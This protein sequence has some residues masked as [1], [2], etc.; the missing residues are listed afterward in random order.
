MWEVAW[1]YLD[2]FLQVRAGGRIPLI[3]GRG[4]TNRA[5]DSM[6]LGPTTTFKQ[7]A[8]P[9]VNVKG[10]SLAQKMVGKAC[11]VDGV[12]PGAYCEPKM[13][14]VG[15]QDTTGPMTRD[16]L[17]DLACLGF[18]ADLVMQS[19]CHTAAYPKPVDVAA[20]EK[21]GDNFG[22]HGMWS[23]RNLKGCLDIPGYFCQMILFQVIT[24][25]TLPKF[26]ADRGGVALRPGDGII[27]SWLNRM[28]LPDEVGTGTELL[29][30]S[31]SE[32]FDVF[33]VFLRFQYV[34]YVSVKP[35]LEKSWIPVAWNGVPRWGFAHAFPTWNFIPG[36]FWI[37]GL[38]SCHWSHAPQHARVRLGAFQ[39]LLRCRGSAYH[40]ISICYQYYGHILNPTWRWD[41]KRYMFHEFF[42]FFRWHLALASFRSRTLFEINRQDAAWCD[43]PWLGACD[44]LLCHPTGSKKTLVFHEMYR[45]QMFFHSTCKYVLW[46]WLLM[47]FLSQLPM[48]SKSWDCFSTFSRF[49]IRASWQW[50][51]RARR[52]SS[53]AVF[54]RLKAFQT[55]NLEDIY[56]ENFLRDW[57]HGKSGF[58][59]M[60]S[61]RIKR[62]CSIKLW[63]D[64][65]C[66]NIAGDFWYPRKCEQ[67]FELSDAS[68]ERSAAGCTIKLNKV[69]AFEGSLD[70]CIIHTDVCFGSL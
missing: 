13:G 17:K 65:K 6:S 61:L 56:W 67:A 54:W 12:V 38:C 57:M 52:T 32:S 66:Q 68:A 21:M 31:P 49:W 41:V 8:Q 60:R 23:W 69:A 63:K 24:H 34:S 58:R 47:F 30:W 27:H 62:C 39:W 35:K 28:L 9:E 40:A 10:F 15:S 2:S 4:L 37:G 19:F 50:R 1:T 18:Q 11:G 3:I 51:R 29:F 44:P 5:R 53:M 59:R 43:S 14:T 48:F 36:W 45:F 20:W 16:E 64:N 33:C 25:R 55:W 7:M 22:D 70:I 26:I 42:L 46:F